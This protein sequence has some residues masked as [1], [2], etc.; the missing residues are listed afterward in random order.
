MGFVY[1]LVYTYVYT[2]E[3]MI[4]SVTDHIISIECNLCRGEWMVWVTRLRPSSMLPDH[5]TNSTK[6]IYLQ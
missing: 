6:V 1:R 3:Y 5:N 2:W 4:E